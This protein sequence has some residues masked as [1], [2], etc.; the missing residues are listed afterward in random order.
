MKRF[1]RVLVAGV[2]LFSGAARSLADDL[3]PPPWVR[4]T[5]PGTTFAEWLFLTPNTQPA[6]DQVINPYG[7]PTALIVPSPLTPAPYT[8][9]DPAS[10]RLGIWSLSGV[11]SLTIPNRPDPSETKW[12]WLQ[13]TWRNTPGL[14]PT[15]PVIGAS[16]PSGAPASVEQYV[17]QALPA[18]WNWS[19]YLMAIRPNPIYETITIAGLIDVDQVVLDT[20]CVPE[21]A[22][23]ILFGLLGSVALGTRWRREG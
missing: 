3:A 4:G 2:L 5:D 19:G 15:G 8:P 7:A 22:A 14:P 6:P 23:L 18:G 9:V 10:G 16:D 21:P 20:Q 17:T 1:F 13:V 11:I 12:I